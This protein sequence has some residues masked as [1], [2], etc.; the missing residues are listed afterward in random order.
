[1][2]AKGNT[3]DVWTPVRAEDG[4]SLTVSG[5]G[6]TYKL[7]QEI[8]FTEDYKR[9]AALT[10]READGADVVVT[11]LCLVRGQGKTEGLRERILPVP[12]RA[13][14]LLATGAGRLQLGT[15]A[16][17]WVGIAGDVQKRVLRPA[18]CMLLQGGPDQAD[19]RDDRAF[20][21]TRRLDELIDAIFFERLWD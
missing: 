5:D 12:R 13:R 8:L 17:K 15:I 18:L 9:G 7:M 20:T 21:W 16:K 4:A 6:F 3:G 19:L 2:D 10:V 1:K 11:A 14:S